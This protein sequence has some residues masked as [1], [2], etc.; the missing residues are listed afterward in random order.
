MKD[1]YKILIDGMDDTLTVTGIVRGVAWVGA[2]LSNGSFGIAMNT[3]GESVQRKFASLVGLGAKTAAQAVMSW[4]FIEA[5]EAMAVINAFYNTPERME[6]LHLA[7]DDAKSCTDGM[8]IE[9]KTVALIGHLK[10]GD[11]ALKGAKEVYIIERD[12]RD[13][14]LPDSACEYIL[15]ECDVSIITGSAAVN[16]TMPRLLELS[17]NAKTVVIGPTVPMC[18]ELKALGI[19]RLSGMVVTDKDGIVDWMQKVRGTPYPFGKSFVID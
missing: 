17:R 8:D 15:P 13:G 12:P 11:G 9:D 6:C 14:D 19:D 2:E 5:S 16:K 7:A 1:Y 4:S 10:L 18:P 3:E